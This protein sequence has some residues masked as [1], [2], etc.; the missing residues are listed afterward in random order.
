MGWQ[1]NF[2]ARAAVCLFT[3]ALLTGCAT[4]RSVLDIR[5]EPSKEATGKAAVKI[6]SVTDKRSFEA[7]PDTPSKPSLKNA[8]EINKPEITARA[9]ARKRNAWGQGLGDILLPEDR[10]VSQLVGEAV[11][12]ALNDKGYAVVAQGSAQYDQAL[13]VSVDIEQFWAWMTPGAWTIGL[14][15]EGRLL[16]QGKVFEGGS[17]TAVRGYF[18]EN[19]G[20]ATESRWTE[21]IQAGITDLINKLK[22]KIVAP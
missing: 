11:T 19:Y 22:E 14:E 9:I 5:V 3:A 4:S 2:S 21:A 12:R 1:W 8:D 20:V 15:F 18:Q 16:L 6:V 17:N 13:P 10:K 7:A